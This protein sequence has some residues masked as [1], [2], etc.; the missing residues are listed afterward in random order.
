MR[1]RELMT[2]NPL[3]CGP[4]TSLL[5]VAGKMVEGDCGMIPVVEADRKPVG[6][7]TDRDI[8]CRAVAKGRNALELRARD[9]MTTPCVTVSPEADLEECARLLEKHQLRRIVVADENG[10]CGVVTQS[11]LA[12]EGAPDKTAEVVR[13]VSQPTRDAA[14]V[15]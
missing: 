5:E 1:V 8:A 14:R 15:R 10:C 3:T 7:V 9:V 2:K 6:T 4:D 12:R 13:K 11:D